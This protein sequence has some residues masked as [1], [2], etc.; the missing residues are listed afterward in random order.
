MITLVVV[1]LLAG[2][3]KSHKQ[4]MFFEDCECEQVAMSGASVMDVS[5]AFKIYLVDDEGWAVDVGFEENPYGLTLTDT[6]GALRG[7]TAVPMEMEDPWPSWEEMDKEIRED[8]NVMENGKVELLNRE[9]RWYL[10]SYDDEIFTHS[11]FVTVED[12]AVGFFYTLNI[13]VD[14][15]KNYKERICEL[16]PLISSFE[17]V[18]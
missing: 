4:S 11:L 7:Y 17:L 14:D 13:S 6:T 18:S 15:A 12:E 1:A 9:C 10:V 5:E 2:C 3:E 16:E 8:F